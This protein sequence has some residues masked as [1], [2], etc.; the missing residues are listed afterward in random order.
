M[1]L[2]HLR[3]KKRDDVKKRAHTANVEAKL[4]GAFK[5]KKIKIT[6]DFDR[7]NCNIIKSIAHEN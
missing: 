5:N 1:Y 6:I 4:E 7:K 2:E 3:R